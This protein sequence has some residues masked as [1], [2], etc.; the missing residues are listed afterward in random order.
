LKTEFELKEQLGEVTKKNETLTIDLDNTTVS[1]GKLEQTN[2][3]LSN[4]L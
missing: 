4:S 3:D 2:Q 1:M